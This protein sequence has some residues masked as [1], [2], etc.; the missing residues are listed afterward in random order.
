MSE[1][2]EKRIL[3]AILPLI[4]VLMLIVWGVK[5]R[6]GETTVMTSANGEWD[7]TSSGLMQKNVRVTGDVEYVPDA[8]LTPQEFSGRTDICL[9]QPDNGTQYATSRMRAEADLGSLVGDAAEGPPGQL[10]HLRVQCGLCKPYV[11]KRRTAF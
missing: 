5:P 1:K 2:K 9:G 4:V 6:T 11:C 10:S 3:A 8:L 7:L